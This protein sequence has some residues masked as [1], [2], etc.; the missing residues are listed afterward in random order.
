VTDCTER[1][2]VAAAHG[3]AG[4]GCTERHSRAAARRI[5]GQGHEGATWG[6]QS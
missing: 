5:A 1:H 2:S 3:I 4:E 6:G